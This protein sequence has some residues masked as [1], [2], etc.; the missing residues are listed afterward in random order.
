[1]YS[2]SC[3]ATNSCGATMTRAARLLLCAADFNCSG[4]LT[5]QDIFDFLT[6]W[7]GANPLADYNGFNGIGVQDIFDFLADWF[8][9]C[10]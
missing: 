9:G 1:M 6:A 4:T 3:T 2:Y 5:V 8:N 10:S 7:F